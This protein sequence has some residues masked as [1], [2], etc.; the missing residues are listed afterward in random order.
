M[1]HPSLVLQT[2]PHVKIK[3][4]KQDIQFFVSDDDDADDDGGGDDDD[5]DDDH[6][7]D[8]SW[9]QSS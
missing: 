3:E 9:I 5:D 6:G 2:T 4:A 8:N 7:V 1:R